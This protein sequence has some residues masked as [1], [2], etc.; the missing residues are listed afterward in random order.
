VTDD[1]RMPP[2][3][4][5]LAGVAG[6]GSLALGALLLSLPLLFPSDLD[7]AAVTLIGYGLISM[8]LGIS[9]C[10]VGRHGW[11]QRPPHRFYAR[12]GW[13]I[14]LVLSLVL[15]V[16]GASI[17]LE[18]QSGFLS[19][20]LHFSMITLPGLLLFSLLSLAA[21]TNAA[22]SIRRMLLGVIGGASSVVLALPVEIIGL[23][24]SA[25]SVMVVMMAMPRGHAEIARV[26]QVYSEW[27]ATS[28]FDESDLVG[29]LS[30]PFV[31]IT[32][33][34]TLAV[35]APAIEEF[36][37]TLVM[38]VLGLRRRTSLLPSFLM[39]AACGLGFAWFEGIGNGALG[40]STSW[41]GSV[42]VRSLAT[43][44]HALTSGIIGLGWGW[45]WRGRRWALPIGYMVAFLLHGLWNLNVVLSLAGVSLM[46]TADGLATVAVALAVLIQLALVGIVAVA[47]FA[48]PLVLRR[49]TKRDLEAT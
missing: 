1:H 32:L 38:G 39:G 33:G 41:G 28:Q 10:V 13:G 25:L 6:L 18:R 15:G 31:L 14:F 17:P 36:G 49:S 19:G 43:A 24:L 48:I 8:T 42:I 40:M 2:W 30:S 9:L 21:G 45:F 29:L 7:A 3:V 37:K 23:F 46:P 47:L 22:L 27:M 4:W 20:T 34:L 11:Q 5:V 26:M 35:I 16:V 12:W 44:M